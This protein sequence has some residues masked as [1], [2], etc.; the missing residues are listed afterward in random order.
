MIV[1][2]QSSLMRRS[3][4]GQV[5]PSPPQTVLVFEPLLSSCL[6][7]QGRKGLTFL[8]RAVMSENLV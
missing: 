1:I 8:N 6:E 3:P 2:F 4:P 5:S 7:F